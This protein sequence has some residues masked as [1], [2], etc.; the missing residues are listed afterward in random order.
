M[1]LIASTKTN[2]LVYCN[3]EYVSIEDDTIAK[4]YEEYVK[5]LNEQKREIDYYA[6]NGL[7]RIYEEARNYEFPEKKGIKINKGGLKMYDIIKEFPEI[8]QHKK[9][10]DLCGGPGGWSKV[11]LDL[12]LSGY[13][14]TILSDSCKMWYEDLENNDKF[15]I[16]HFENN[17][18]TKEFVRTS[19]ISNVHNVSLVVADGAPSLD[20]GGD[21]CKQ[22]NYSCK[23]IY[24]EVFIALNIL[25]TGGTFV[26]KI[27]DTFKQH[28]QHLI[29]ILTLIFKK[30][31]IYKPPNSRIV[32]SEKY[33]I[34]LHKYAKAKDIL[35]LFIKVFENWE[36]GTIP[37]ALIPSR[38]MSLDNKFKSYFNLFI[39]E[40][41][42][43]QI[44]A[45]KKVMETLQ[46]MLFPTNKEI[47]NTREQN[48]NDKKGK[49]K[50]KGK[51][52]GKFE[53]CDTSTTGKGW[54]T[55]N[56]VQNYQRRSYPYQSK[57]KW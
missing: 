13:G 28:T 6:A 41:T 21:E 3:I 17:D 29:Y 55:Q 49:P 46:Q 27:F 19:L 40:Y 9:F 24:S 26:F 2:K 1:Y 39:E 56:Y 34:C 33:V 43:K 52:K 44:L 10:L 45:L 48:Y 54:G 23:L 36:D 11:L 16:L 4:E 51:G 25:C 38:I 35:P 32:N 22:E 5:K 50:G 20:V 57:G 14:I 53:I 8:S 30:V 12:G 15:T 42:K 7:K 18:I 31:Y 37:S 47:D